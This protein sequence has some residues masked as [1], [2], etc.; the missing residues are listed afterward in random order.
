MLRDGL[1]ED[2]PLDV[3]ISKISGSKNDV[4]CAQSRVDI[5]QDILDRLNSLAHK[6]YAPATEESRLA[7][8]GAGLSDND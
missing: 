6:T 5:P 4:L 8:A 7:G 2:G 3:S 1:Y